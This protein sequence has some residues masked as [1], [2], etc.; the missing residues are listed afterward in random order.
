MGGRSWPCLY[1][2]ITWAG[3][4]TFPASL[5][6]S[7]T[8]LLFTVTEWSVEP[9]PALKALQYWAFQLRDVRS[10]PGHDGMHQGS[11]CHCHLGTTLA[12]L[13]GYTEVAR[14]PYCWG[15]GT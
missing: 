1:Q 14:A 15:G 12:A 13:P 3:D 9:T 8:V 2:W 11:L 5:N 6:P 4:L 10:F 7:I